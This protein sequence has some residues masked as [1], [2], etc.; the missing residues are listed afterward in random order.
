MNLKKLL[1]ALIPLFPISHSLA[2][3]GVY[4][5]ETSEI[6]NE[7]VEFKKDEIWVATNSSIY[8]FKNQGKQRTLFDASS[9]NDPPGIIHTITSGKDSLWMGCDSGVYKFDGMAWN[10]LNLSGVK[11]PVYE[12]KFS[13]DHKMWFV[14]GQ[15]VFSLLGSNL[16]NENITGNCLATFQ[17]EVFVGTN[18]HSGTGWH[19]KNGVWSAIPNANSFKTRAIHEIEVDGLG[20]LWAAN[21]NGISLFDG[22]NW[23]DHYTYLTSCKD[24]VV[25]NN[26][27]YSSINISNS[28]GENTGNLIRVSI[29]GNADTIIHPA[30]ADSDRNAQ[31]AK[32]VNGSILMAKDFPKSIFKFFPSVHK[33]NSYAELAKNEIKAGIYANGDL[34]RN[35]NDRLVTKGLKVEDRLAVYAGSLWLTGKDQSNLDRHAANTYGGE[36]DFFSGPIAGVYDSLY[37]SKYNRVWKINRSQIAIHKTDFNKPG[38]SIP[39]AILN[40]PGNG[41]QNKGEAKYYAPF[42]DVNFNEVYEPEL[43]D[44]PDMMGDEAIFTLYNDA[45]GP[46]RNTEMANMGLEIHCMIY[47]YDSPSNLALHNSMFVRYKVINKST[48]NYSDFKLGIWNDMD[49]GNS[50]DDMVG[51][52]SIKDCFFAYN[53]DNNDDGPNGYGLNP[54]AFGGVFLSKSMSG[55]AYSQNSGSGPVIPAALVDPSTAV[56]FIRKMSNRWLD[57]EALRLENPSGFMDATGINGDGYDPLAISPKTNFAFNSANNWYQSNSGDMRCMARADVGQLNAGDISC[58]DIAL[59]YARDKTNPN[60]DASLN[61]FRTYADSVKSFYNKQNP[62]CIGESIGFEEISQDSP[63][64]INF[65][66]NPVL[67]GNLL[68]IDLEKELKSVS[69]FDLQGKL[70]LQ[71]TFN[72]KS[73]QYLKIPNNINAGFY[74][75]LLESLDGEKYASK[76]SVD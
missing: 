72:S 5:G 1:L 28:S 24:L 66:P 73:N 49:L 55:F 60:L 12:I 56:E 20:N 48:E 6:A 64:N 44:Y 39:E 35:Y 38:Y 27:A 11:W 14:S 61:V 16:I 63:T 7:I 46:K 62:A 75:I 31:I 36:S 43:G 9:F 13:I 52:D 41:D 29:N 40:W 2:Q 34:F 67:R 45:R 51:C 22:S 74:L 70:I 8:K 59:I 15:T 65:Y 4:T 42:I 76:L 18:L 54:P 33:S 25:L 69:I 10:K 47:A 37:I 53:G 30:G 71:K 32:G 68:K 17:T 19:K 50:K 26:R 58:F 3:S 23:H 57:G 21:D